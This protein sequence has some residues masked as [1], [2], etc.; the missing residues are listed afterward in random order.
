MGVLDLNSAAGALR[1]F[2]SII[3]KLL[4]MLVPLDRYEI[5]NPAAAAAD[6]LLDATASV[7]SPVTVLK[8]QLK[9]PGLAALAAYPRRVTIT[10]A[11]VTP[12]N[13]PATALITGLDCNGNVLTETVNVPQT[14]T[15]VSTAKFFAD[16]TSVAYPA[17]D[18]TAAT[19]AIGFGAEIG[20]KSEPK[21]VNGAVAAIAEFT[22][23]VPSGTRATYI[24]PANG[25]P[26]GGATFNTAPNATND[27]A[28]WFERV[29]SL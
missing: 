27:Y 29:F 2:P 24:T 9:A 4:T 28:V 16:I 10:T 8:S 19:M 22:N 5:T 13:A 7:A 12:A 18:G 21:L 17:A 6:G 25:L 26:F 20:F 11:G 15:V 3:A 1:A 23:G 14:A